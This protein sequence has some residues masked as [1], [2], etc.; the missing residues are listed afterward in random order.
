MR[1]NLF[2]HNTLEKMCSTIELSETQINDANKWLEYLSKDQLTNEK[3]NYLIFSKLIL[4]SLL[5]YNTENLNHEVGNI[6][7][8]YPKVGS[9]VLGI[10][11]KGTKTDI[12]SKQK[13][14]KE[15]HDT[16]IHQLW[17]YMGE[18]N[19]KYGIATNYESFVLIDKNEGI[20][21][22]HIF[23]F[24]S[25]ES[26]VDN[27]KEFIAVFSRKY[28]IDDN[29]VNELKEKSKLE[30]REFTNEF[31]GLFS[32]T[33]L[34]LIQEFEQNG[35]IKAEA[36]HHAQLFLNRLMFIFFCEDGRSS[37]RPRFNSLSFPNS[38][39]ASRTSA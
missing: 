29:F 27:L 7:F 1:Q 28:L 21:K 8:S 4:E 6:E 24:K 22:V 33:R 2:K 35:A 13:R 19:L 11:A 20:S 9:P 16:P 18:M 10:E 36:I 38:N 17:S 3:E 30:E 23:N 25:I 12:F 39:A 34:M 37:F 26:N 15:W 5:G 14:R 31:Y 32:E